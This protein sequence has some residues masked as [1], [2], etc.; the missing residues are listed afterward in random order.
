M[1][2][3][4]LSCNCDG[5][6]GTNPSQLHESLHVGATS[7]IF[8]HATFEKIKAGC[9]VCHQ[10]LWLAPSVRCVIPRL[11]S[12]GHCSTIVHFLQHY[13]QP[14]RE[15]GQ[16]WLT[17][18]SHLNVILS[19]WRYL[20]KEPDPV[21]P[22]VHHTLPGPAHFLHLAIQHLHEGEIP[23]TQSSPSGSSFPCVRPVNVNWC[24]SL[25]QVIY[26]GCAYATVYLIYMKFRATYDGNHDSFR[27][28]FLVVPVGGLA[29]L[30]NHDF[31][32]LEVSS[33]S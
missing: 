25:P 10:W 32:F 12:R 6:V 21:C 28:E 16:R 15:A 3:I 17:V 30:V 5:F 13:I 22:C 27:M 18:D 8:H 23:V 2:K 20:W 26:I 4:K 11:S 31:S 29:V 14:V 19:P 9:F 24:V 33:A 7:V 1:W